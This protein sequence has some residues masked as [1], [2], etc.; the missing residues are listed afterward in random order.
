MSPTGTV[1][2]V[3][4]EEDFK[5]TR[6]GGNILTGVVETPAFDEAYSKAMCVDWSKLHA[7]NRR[8]PFV[9]FVNSKNERKQN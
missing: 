3:T 7:T 8:F 1:K 2:T 9:G 4:A 6:A 5:P